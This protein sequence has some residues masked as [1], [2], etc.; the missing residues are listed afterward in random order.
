MVVNL[1]K[2]YA[3]SGVSVADLVPGEAALCFRCSWPGWELARRGRGCSRLG[4]A[5]AARAR[6]PPSPIP[7]AG[8]PEPCAS[9]RLHAPLRLDMQ[10]AC[11]ACPRR[12]TALSP[13]AASRSPPFHTGG[14]GS[15]CRAPSPVRGWLGLGVGS[16]GWVR[17]WV[18]GVGGL[19][20]GEQR[21]DG[22]GSLRWLAA[23]P[24]CSAAPHRRPPHRSLP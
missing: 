13:R 19:G 8:L 17:P 4:G 20:A 5:G 15:R 7:V 9:A 21:S 18:G 2:R 22:E 10:R 23:S 24:P 11:R 6:P 1:A 3:G 14:S 16:R 12:S